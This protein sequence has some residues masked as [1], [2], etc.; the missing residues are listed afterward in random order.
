M[1]AF[2]AMRCVPQVACV[3]MLAGCTTSQPPPPRAEPD[4]PPDHRK[5]IADN[6]QTLF[7]ADA[8]VRNVSIS[9]L[10]WAP[11]PSGMIWQTC[12]RVGGATSVT[13]LETT[14]RTYVVTFVRNTIAERR[15]ASADECAGAKFSPLR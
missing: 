7:T 9:E 3:M 11:S 14:P 15:L 2:A 8:Q 5:L 6:L 4:P 1:F 10:N 12:L 13:G